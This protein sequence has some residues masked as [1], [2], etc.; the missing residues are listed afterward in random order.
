MSTEPPERE[1]IVVIT[2]GALSATNGAGLF[3]RWGVS[4]TIRSSYN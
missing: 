1:V 2:T 3:T 4:L